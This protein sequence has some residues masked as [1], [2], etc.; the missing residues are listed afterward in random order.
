[1]GAI[2]PATTGY[3]KNDA[4]H[5][6]SFARCVLLAMSKPENVDINEI[7]FQPAAQVL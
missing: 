1:M 4:I 7:L 6:E 3:Y 5:A 2:A